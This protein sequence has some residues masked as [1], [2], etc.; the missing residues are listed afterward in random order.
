MFKASSKLF[1]ACLL[2]RTYFFACLS[3]FII[4][5]RVYSLF[6]II[7]RVLFISLIF[8]VFKACLN[9]F[10]FV[11]FISLL[12]FV[13]T[14]CSKLF[15]VSF[16]FIMIFSC[17]MLVQIIFRVSYLFYY[18]PVFQRCLLQPPAFPNYPQVHYPLNKS[19]ISYYAPKLHLY[20]K[21]KV[22]IYFEH[23]SRILLLINCYVS[24]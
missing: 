8:F 6:K 20:N 14:A 5:F 2:V 24:D 16:Y 12:F 10:S 21:T 11:L 9:Y 3:Y 22:R 15:F 7:F 18:F 4:I 17:L 13:F 1:V 23:T 19:R